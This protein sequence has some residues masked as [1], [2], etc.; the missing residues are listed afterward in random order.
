MSMDHFHN[1]RVSLGCRKKERAR[2]LVPGDLV[3]L[4]GLVPLGPE[5]L[6][7]DRARAEVGKQSKNTL[8]DIFERYIEGYM[9]LFDAI[10]SV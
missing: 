10:W 1:F 6:R 3:V 9:T 4:G 7:A 2:G 8:L 5:H